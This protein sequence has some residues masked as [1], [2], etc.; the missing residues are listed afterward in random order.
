MHSR[1]GECADAVALSR[2]PYR[3]HAAPDRELVTAAATCAKA[4][5]RVAEA[6]AGVEIRGRTF[7]LLDNAG[8]KI[9]R[10][11]RRRQLRCGTAGHV[12]LAADRARPN[13]DRVLGSA[14]SRPI[15]RQGSF[16][17]D[18][19]GPADHVAPT[20]CAC[21]IDR[22]VCFRKKGKRCLVTSN[23]TGF[24]QSI[25]CFL[26]NGHPPAPFRADG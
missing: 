18:A 15:G 14:T 1:A 19:A 4:L 9:G 7:D 17:T 26:C 25:E 3:L 6:N 24:W 2:D 11:L 23:A 10:E 16:V 8:R 21:H 22:I 13:R 12:N 5:V 20:V